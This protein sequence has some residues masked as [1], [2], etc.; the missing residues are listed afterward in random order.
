[1]FYTLYS[2]VYL[3]VNTTYCTV[4]STIYSK[5]LSFVKFNSAKSATSAARAAKFSVFKKHTVDLENQY[6]LVFFIFILGQSKLKS[7]IKT[8]NFGQYE[9]GNC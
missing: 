2:T 5:K 1:M 6:F 4:Y 7:N 3:R 8:C 9:K